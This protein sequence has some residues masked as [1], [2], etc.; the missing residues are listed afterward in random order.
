[1]I[2]MRIKA[3]PKTIIQFLKISY[4]A[5]STVHIVKNKGEVS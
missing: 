2:D 5:V 1:M 4:T 3:D